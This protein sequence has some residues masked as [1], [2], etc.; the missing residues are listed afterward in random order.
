MALLDPASR[1]R[2]RARFYCSVRHHA[3]S[4]H[5]TTP[6]LRTR[7]SQ[8]RVLQGAPAFARLRWYASYGWQATA[9]AR[10]R[11]RASYGCQAIGYRAEVRIDPTEPRRAGRTNLY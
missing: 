11:R 3:T 4:Y 7:R 5:M 6:Q 2:D 9:F 10:I 8:V 1:S